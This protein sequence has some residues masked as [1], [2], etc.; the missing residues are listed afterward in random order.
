MNKYR[1]AL[2]NKRLNFRRF[3]DIVAD[4]AITAASK[5]KLQLK[6]LG[7]DEVESCTL[8]EFLG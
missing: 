6:G 3:L 8:I 5:A 2:I 7:Y 1:I 4:T